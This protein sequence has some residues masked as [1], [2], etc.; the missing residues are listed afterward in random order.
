VKPL[1]TL[2]ALAVLVGCAIELPPDVRQADQ[3]LAA[4]P[5][6]PG[7]RVADLGAG[8]GYLA[9][10]LAE[11]VGPSGVVYAVEVDPAALARL[12]ERAASAGRTNVVAIEAAI[13]D[14]RLRD[15]SVDLAVVVGTYAGL[16]NR[17]SYFERVRPALRPGGRVA[18][19][20]ITEPELFV[21]P[22]P[23]AD[24]IVNQLAAAGFTLAERR[25]LLERRTLLIFTPSP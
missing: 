9:L 11:A 16:G 24:G 4:L 2:A 17:T 15:A 20:E 14:P 10:R 5:L 18:I 19:V 25:A 12:R 8:S 22:P 3:A 6:A 13:D 1:A 21:P 7:M 23:T